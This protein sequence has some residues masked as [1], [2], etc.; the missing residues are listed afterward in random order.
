M[1]KFTQFGNFFRRSAKVQQDS[2]P[3]ESGIYKSLDSP[4]LNYQTTKTSNGTS[5][6]L[7]N[8]TTIGAIN[9]RLALA[10]VTKD[11]ESYK[12]I[13]IEKFQYLIDHY[14]ILGAAKIITK[15]VE[16]NDINIDQI[17]Y[18]LSPSGYLVLSAIL[19][20]NDKF[21]DSIDALEKINEIYPES[22]IPDFAISQAK[23][24]LVSC[25]ISPV[26]FE[27]ILKFAEISHSKIIKNKDIAAT[28]IETE[29]GSII[30]DS[31]KQLCES[32]RSELSQV[33]VDARQNT[34]KD[35][36][37]LFLK[38]FDKKINLALANNDQDLY[39]NNLLHKAEYLG[40]SGNVSGAADIYSL[41]V[42]RSN[43]EL[44]KS[45][46]MSFLRS[47]EAS[48]EYKDAIEL[49][50][51][52]LSLY[53]K[54]YE[55]L[56]IKARSKLCINDHVDA[57]GPIN[58]AIKIIEHKMRNTDSDS[59]LGSCKSSILEILATK[60]LIFGRMERYSDAAICL[61]KIS[62]S[63]LNGHQFISPFDKELTPED[64]SL[65][66]SNIL[67]PTVK[68]LGS[69]MCDLHESNISPHEKKLLLNA[70]EVLDVFKFFI[71][72]PNRTYDR[73]DTT[74]CLVDKQNVL[75]AS[76]A[77]GASLEQD[78]KII[79]ESNHSENIQ[80]SD[81]QYP[82]SSMNDFS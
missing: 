50:D 13:S 41:A 12:N 52:M 7:Q 59:E 48:G 77:Q 53:P 10:Q 8:T 38:E 47:L 45:H 73:Y 43:R 75:F 24:F 32:P 70:D 61:E 80:T 54:S 49:S 34:N 4:T 21:M 37:D 19:L 65:W 81:L 25:D 11:Q 9:A 79:Q 29:V 40:S 58:R 28:E 42:E 17:G 6:I 68:A 23:D 15:F 39:I 16:K 69:F 46:Y 72:A 1:L 14:N 74:L 63:I 55:I 30:S 27:K 5:S 22:P 62:S 66:H 44:D 26:N 64:I 57:L 33:M 71:Y 67:F 82:D 51:L 76:A 60:A 35:N 18:K 56:M 3:S 2:D 36:G 20:C 78:H 31:S